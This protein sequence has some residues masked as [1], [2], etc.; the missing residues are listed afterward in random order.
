MFFKQKIYY[1]NSLRLQ[2]KTQSLQI[3]LPTTQSKKT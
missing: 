3:T 1:V 2:Q